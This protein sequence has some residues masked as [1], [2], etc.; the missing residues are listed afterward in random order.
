MSVFLNIFEASGSEAES[1]MCLVHIDLLT[2]VLEVD[3]RTSK[4]CHM[5]EYLTA[6]FYLIN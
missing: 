6:Y 2:S 3:I 1:L 5:E 4:E